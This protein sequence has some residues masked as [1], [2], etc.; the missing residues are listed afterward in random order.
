MLYG[1]CKITAAIKMWASNFYELQITAGSIQND[2]GFI[3][4]GNRIVIRKIKPQNP[5][6]NPLA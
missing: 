6:F 4:R 5:L 3:Y 1:N 2:Y